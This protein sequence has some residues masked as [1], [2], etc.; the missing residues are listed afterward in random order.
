MNIRFKKVLKVGLTSVG[1]ALVLSNCLSNNNSSMIVSNFIYKTDSADEDQNKKELASVNGQYNLISMMIRNNSYGIIASE[2]DGEKVLKK[3]GENYIDNSLIDKSNILDVDVKTNINYEKCSEEVT[4]VDSI[5][6]IAKKIIDDNKENNLFKVDLKC[7]EIRKEEIKPAVKTINKDDM[8]IGEVK[9]EDGSS[10]YK[11][12][13]CKVT[14]TNGVKVGEEV[15]EEKTVLA[16][17]DAIIYKGCKNPINDRV[18]FLEHPTKG[19]TITSAFGYRWGKKHNGIDIAHKTGD[20][21][22]CAFDGKVKECGYVN[23]YGNRIVIEHEGN[24]QTVYAHLSSIQ[25]KAMTDVKKGDLIGLVGSTGKSTGPH[26]HFEVR[27][28]GV[29]INPEGYIKV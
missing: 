12:V 5:D 17:K 4:T 16:S 13:T 22:Y 2:E 18:A 27:V 14:Y 15:L 25:T 29:P 8:Y 19:G 10:G 28:N 21:V 6:N 20:P 23:G 3:I 24:I 1:F 9:K 26:L 7:R 11:E